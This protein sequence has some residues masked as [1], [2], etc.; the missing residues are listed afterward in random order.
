MKGIRGGGGGGKSKLTRAREAGSRVRRKA[1]LPDAA[2]AMD[3]ARRLSGLAC[4]RIG[5]PTEL[6][7]PMGLVGVR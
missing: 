1:G 7:S 6:W 5:G 2:A 3:G 4:G